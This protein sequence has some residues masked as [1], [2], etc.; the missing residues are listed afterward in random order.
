MT[1]HSASFSLTLRVRL[2]N[3]PGSFADLARAIADAG[4]LL[5]AIDLVRVSS[6]DKTR[7]VSVLATDEAHADAIV[8]ACR[9]IEGV[10]VE[11]VSDRTFLLHLGGKLAMNSKAP[12]KTRDD[13]SM[14]Y[15][16]GV[17]RCLLYTSRCV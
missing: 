6:N 1:H 8:A 5:D 14:A 3:R 11:H 13:L 7:D 17:A 12:I 16:P 4:G 2:D 15:T 9:Q 10:D